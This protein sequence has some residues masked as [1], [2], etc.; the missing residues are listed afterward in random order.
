MKSQ[1]FPVR[2][3]ALPTHLGILEV[4]PEKE[5]KSTN[6]SLIAPSFTNMDVAKE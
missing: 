2:L 1:S 4:I 3:V 5:G 6:T